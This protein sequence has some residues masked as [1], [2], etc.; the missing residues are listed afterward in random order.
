MKTVDTNEYMTVLQGLIEEGKEVGLLISGDSM[1]P[2]L[3]HQRDYIYFKSPDRELKKGDMVFYRRMT[4]QY[5]MHRILDVKPEGY[6][7][8]GDNQMQVEGPL[9]RSQ[10]FAIVTKVKRKGRIIGPENL[11]WKFYE[12][13]WIHMIPAR[14]IIGRVCRK[15]ERMVKGQE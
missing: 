7:M 8:I 13:V 4:G 9:D 2:F 10:I 5:I 1:A 3:A 14:G 6:Y 12:K 15:L 11:V